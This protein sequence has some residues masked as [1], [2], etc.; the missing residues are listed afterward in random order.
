MDTQNKLCALSSFIE[1]QYTNGHIQYGEMGML[2]VYCVD[3]EE[4]LSKQNAGIEAFKKRAESS[5]RV[6]TDVLAQLKEQNTDT[7]IVNWMDR[8]R[9]YK[10]FRDIDDT[11][12]CMR[13]LKTKAMKGE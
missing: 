11:L 2:R 9:L 4:E 5:E 1:K 13:D 3:I 8:Q 6:L 12:S 7:E 10:R